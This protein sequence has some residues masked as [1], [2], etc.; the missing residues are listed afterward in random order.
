MARLLPIAAAAAGALLLLSPTWAAETVKDCPACPKLVRLPYGTLI[1]AYPVTRAEYRVFVEETG[2][3]GEGCSLRSGTGRSWSEQADWS[4]PG[5]PQADDHPVVCVNW[6]DAV[7]YA[8]WLTERTG[9]NYRLPSLEESARAAAGGA[10][11]EFWW[12]DDYGAI[13]QHANVADRSFHAKFPEDGREL[14]ACDDGYANTA[15]VTAFPANGYGLHDAAGNVWNWTNSCL[16]GD[17][18]NAIFR[19]GG[20]DTPVRRYFH[21]NEYFGDRIVLRNDVIGIRVLRDGD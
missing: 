7:A 19:G 18:S 17:C 8:D 10:S 3:T 11:T 2:R 12:G 14:L 21:P 1:G 13:C 9:H 4:D 5:Y 6:N 16:R 15:P 20:W